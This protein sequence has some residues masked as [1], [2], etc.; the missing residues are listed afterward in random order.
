MKLNLLIALFVFT[1]TNKIVSQNEFNICFLVYD[2]TYNKENLIQLAENLY[3]KDKIKFNNLTIYHFNKENKKEI[4]SLSKKSKIEYIERKTDCKF[5]FC[6]NLDSYF[7]L[8]SKERNK[9]FFNGPEF[10]CNTE[11][12]NMEFSKIP[13]R[14]NSFISQKIKEEIII[15]K[16]MKQNTSLF[17]C[18]IDGKLNNQF[19][20]NFESDTI[21]LNADEEFQIK[22]KYSNSVSKVSWEPKEKFIVP[23]DFYPV[24]KTD[25]SAQIS[26]TISDSSNCNSLTKNIYL[27]IKND[28]K[29]GKNL[30]S[31]KD[32]FKENKFKKYK[33]SDANFYDY[34]LPSIQSGTYVYELIMYKNCASKFYLSIEDKNGKIVKASET[35]FRNDV[36]ER[37]QSYSRKDFQNYFIFRL[38]LSNYSEIMDDGE[39]SNKIIIISVDDEG[40]ACSKYVSP[41]LTFIVCE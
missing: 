35:Y 8:Q 13:S 6:D 4:I 21:K 37:S 36:D 17:F 2:K 16:S 26:L 31:L 14:D 23:T 24:V 30:E 1:L 10:S 9:F 28:C 20:V 11:Q 12:L 41:R 32:I 27:Q 34:K 3:N 18:F 33:K 39:N 19:Y 40:K 22:P 5:S 25:K 7:S 15:N 29:C 38:D